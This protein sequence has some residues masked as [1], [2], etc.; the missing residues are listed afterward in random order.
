LFLKLHDFTVA[1][2]RRFALSE[3]WEAHVHSA[4]QQALHGDASLGLIARETSTDRTCG[5]AL[6]AVHCDSALWR[7]REWA[8]VEALYV[9]D[10]WRGRGLAEA[11][12]AC[13]CAWAQDRGQAVVQLCVTASNARALAFYRHEGFRET[14][15]IMRKVLIQEASGQ[16]TNRNGG[17]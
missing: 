16:L 12:L 8:E 9:E 13:V 6:A 5:F 4:L 15:A 1:L 3:D 2:D 11:L 10:A 7:Y 17:R 14:Q